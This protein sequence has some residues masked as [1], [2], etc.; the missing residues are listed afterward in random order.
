MTLNFIDA[1]TKA[2]SICKHYDA[3]GNMWFLRDDSSAPTFVRVRAFRAGF[4]RAY[5]INGPSSPD[6][7]LNN[8]W[9]H[10]EA[11]QLLR[12]VDR[13]WAWGVGE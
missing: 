7:T 2:R 3:K 11:E 4:R 10:R 5:R 13:A 9:E 8:V 12:N 1:V 6:N